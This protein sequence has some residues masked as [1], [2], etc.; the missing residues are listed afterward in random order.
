MCISNS[1]L[2]LQFGSRYARA[3]LTLELHGHWRSP[4]RLYAPS[5]IWTSMPLYKQCYAT[6][7]Y[8]Q[9]PQHNSPCSRL[10][11]LFP[12]LYRTH[13][14]QVLPVFSRPSSILHSAHPLH[15][16]VHYPSPFPSLPLD[17]RPLS[18]CIH[19]QSHS[20]SHNHHRLF[21]NTRLYRPHQSL[22]SAPH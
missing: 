7:N 18:P 6:L 9:T 21:L 11:I 2:M 22:L 16:A 4:P 12:F 8:A 10:S 17:H 20:P 5:S 1:V 14:F 15:P 3:S 13:P 19:Y